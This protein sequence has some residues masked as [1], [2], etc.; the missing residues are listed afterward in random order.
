[1][2]PLRVAVRAVEVI[3]I[4]GPAGVGK[5]TAARR[6]AERLGYYFL[7]SG[8]IYRAMAWHLL[9]RGWRVE[10]GVPSPGEVER[11]LAGLDVQVAPGGRIQAAGRDVTDAL[12]GEAVSQ[13][14]SVLSALP[15]VRA[16]SNEIQR[17]TVAGIAAAGIY[18]GVVLEGR[19]IGTVVF[20]DAAHKFFLTATEA[21]RAQ[22]RFTEQGPGKSAASLA[23]VQ[24]SLQERDARDSRRAVA[25]LVPAPDAQIVDTSDLTVE[26]VLERILAELKG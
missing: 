11:N 23:E 1:V 18:P 15:A 25:P 20:P 3:A 24:A 17:R 22:R 5:S 26:Q 6:L 4:D 9:G 10:A 19:D 21:V 14:A 12:R 13:A 8:M 2:N 7:S 16:R